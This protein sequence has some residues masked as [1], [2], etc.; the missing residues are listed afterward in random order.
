MKFSALPALAVF[1]CLASSINAAQDE[2]AQLSQLLG[3]AANDILGQLR[4]E[5]GALAKRGVEASCTVRNIAIRREFGSMAPED[6]KAYTDA[7]QC[8]QR[9]SNLTP[10]SLVPGARTR[11]DDFVAVHQNQTPY[12]HFSGTFLGWH[13]YFI[14]HYEQALR[15]ECGYKGYQPYWDWSKWAAAPQDSPMFDGSPYSMGGN[16]EFI[17]HDPLVLL[18]PVEGANPPIVIDAGLGGGC[19]QSGPFSNMSVNLGP[20]GLTNTPPGPDG[21]LGYNPRCL[22]RDVGP[23]CLQKYNNYTRIWNLMTQR[24]NIRD[25]QLDLEGPPGTGDLGPHGGGHFAIGGDPGGDLFTSPGDPAF[26]LHHGQ[27]DRLWTLWQALDPATRRNALD[28]TN[29]MLN[30][31]PSAN[32]TLEDFINLG[33]A[34]GQPIQMKNVMSTVTGPFCYIYL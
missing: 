15:N 32:T 29:T 8:L 23:F 9:K 18:P 6:R 21:G 2:A 31:P 33:Y 27:V 25:F 4:E 24:H 10:N 16:G 34:A 26:Y 19:V 14:W 5:E 7:V 17:P 3:E 22:K 12:I 20:I 11:F 13:R 1:S 28:G 30:D